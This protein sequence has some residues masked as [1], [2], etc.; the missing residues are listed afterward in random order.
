MSNAAEM[1]RLRARVRELETQLSATAADAEEHPDQPARRSVWWTMCSGV[2]LVLACVLAPLSVA[3]VWASMQISDTEQYVDTVAPLAEDPAVQAAI[4]DEVTALVLDRLDV[5]QL[6]TDALAALAQQDNVPPRVS[7]ALPALAVPI[8]SGFENFARTQVRNIVASPEFATVWASVNR[9]A[10]EQ[11]VK[12]LEGN[13]GG[14]VTAQGDAITLNLGPIVEQVKSRL[15][16]RGF[17]LAQNIPVVDRT[18][19]L[20]QSETIRQTQVFY[21]L[22]NTLGAWLPL[23]VLVLFTI[24]VFLAKDRRQA[25]LRGALGVTM[26]MIVLGVLLAVGRM[27]YVQSTPADVFTEQ[28]AGNVFDTLVRFLRTGLRAVAVL[29]LVVA[30]AA[31]F[32]GPSSAALRTRGALSSGIAS[33]RGKAEGVGWQT[34]RFGAWIYANRTPLR[35]GV[36]FA[37]GLVLMFWARPTAGVVLTTAVLVVIALAVIEFLGQPTLRVAAGPPL[38]APGDPTVDRGVPGPDEVTLARSSEQDDALP[39]VRR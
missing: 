28:A 35:I 21:R 15:V 16:A 12:L 9:I 22:L 23:A 33:L 2:V 17:T 11:V 14:A 5:E 4:A 6:T 34:G 24:G 3:S 31:F 18:F 32:A 37:G 7:E 19:V 29:G 8:S 1:E 39:T 30:A 26:A 25:T 13:A 20:V 38:A 36:A 10:H 27:L